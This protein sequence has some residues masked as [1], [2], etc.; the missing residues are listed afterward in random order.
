MHLLK[1]MCMLSLRKETC[2]KR[3]G[4]S[5][6]AIAHNVRHCQPQRAN[7]LLIFLAPYNSTTSVKAPIVSP[8]VMYELRK[9]LTV[10][11]DVPSAPIQDGQAF[12][13]SAHLPIWYV[14]SPQQGRKLVRTCEALDRQATL[15]PANL[16][17]HIHCTHQSTLQSLLHAPS[18][19]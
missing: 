4:V 1:D 2:L 9:R 18:K 12:Q 7:L 6:L 17:P 11:S 10:L 19:H 16:V 13:H 5:D 3:P 14:S 15:H 8:Q